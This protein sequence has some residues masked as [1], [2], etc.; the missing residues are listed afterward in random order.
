MP[1]FSQRMQLVQSPMIPVV[2]EWIRA[3]P[4]T[5]SLGQGVVSYGPPPEA[6]QRVAQYLAAAAPTTTN[7]SWWPAST[8]CSSA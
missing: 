7:T 2:G 3:H 4:G 8:N 6:A 5:I 1:S